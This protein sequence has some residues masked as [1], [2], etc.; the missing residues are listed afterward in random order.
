MKN[1]V[2]QGNTAR[3]KGAAPKTE[4]RRFFLFAAAFLLGAAFLLFGIYRNEVA[5]VLKK[6]IFICLECIGIG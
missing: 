2:K 6:A 4:R 1:P 3:R 5:T